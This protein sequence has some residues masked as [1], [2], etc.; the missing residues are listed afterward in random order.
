MNQVFQRL[1]EAVQFAVQTCHRTKQH[2]FV[3]FVRKPP[4]Y[5]GNVGVDRTVCLRDNVGVDRTVCLRGNVGVDRT[6]CLRG[7]LGVDRTVCLRG[8][9]CL[10][11]TLG[12]DRT[13][14]LQCNSVRRVTPQ[15]GVGLVARMAM[16]EICNSPVSQAG[17]LVEQRQVCALYKLE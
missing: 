4:K 2:Q 8:N 6:V 3:D 12:V 17:L 1:L 16:D 9:V 14:C 11:G 15:G 5:R 13:V 10:R 7:T